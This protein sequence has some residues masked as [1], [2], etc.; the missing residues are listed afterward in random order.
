MARFGAFL[1]AFVAIGL[2]SGS[3]AA[4]PLTVLSFEGLQDSE[5]ILDFYNGGTG[6]LGSSGPNYGIGFG[7]DALSLIDSDA[8]GSGNFANEPSP[9][10]IAFFLTGPGV[11]MNV[12]SGFD[13]G[14]SFFYSSTVVATVDVYDGLN[15]TGNLLGTLNLAAQAGASEGCQL[16]GDPNG[17]FAC[18]DPVGVAFA[19][20]AKSA[21]FGG[22]ANV[23]GFDSITLGSDVPD[24]DPVIPEPGA[25]ALFGVS[26]LLL[27]LVGRRSNRR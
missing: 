4:L 10:T 22:A 5:Q 12:A 7:A 20:T 15:A 11:V 16:P 3:A 2:W 6:S 9:D 19:G 13:T 14:F 27:G 25:T 1:T 8:G 17:Y 24:P 23:T 21:N 26:A 18:W